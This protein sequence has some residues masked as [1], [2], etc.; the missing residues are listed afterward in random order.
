MKYPSS[1]IQSA[2]LKV[3][4]LLSLSVL[5]NAYFPSENFTGSSVSCDSAL[6]CNQKGDSI[7]FQESG[8]TI[9]EVNKEMVADRIEGRDMLI[10]LEK[11]EQP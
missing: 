5:L 1:K 7:A 6:D 10:E 3:I 8:K 2:F 9:S 11:F 4:S